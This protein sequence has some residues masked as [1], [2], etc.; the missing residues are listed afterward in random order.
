MRA[1]SRSHRFVAGLVALCLTLAA[2]NSSAQPAEP[3]LIPLQTF[4]LKMR[5]VG[6]LASSEEICKLLGHQFFCGLPTLID[7]LTA[8]APP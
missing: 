8:K 1:P 7:C 5:S 6:L 4:D 2:K 3:L